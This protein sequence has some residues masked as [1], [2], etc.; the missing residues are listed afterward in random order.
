MR[1][2]TN[3]LKKIKSHPAFFLVPS[4]A[5]MLVFF[6]IPYI[7]MVYYSFL[8]NPIRK[9][10]IGFE[11]YKTVLTNRAFQTAVNNTFLFTVFAVP[12]AVILGL[13]LAEDSG[14]KLFQE[15]HA[16]AAYG[17]YGIGGADISGAV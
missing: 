3:I 5:G 16:D 1:K 4:L 12:M 14:Q 6:V 17:A 15:Q 11:N 2:F 9:E 7:I 10:F 8:D 13:L